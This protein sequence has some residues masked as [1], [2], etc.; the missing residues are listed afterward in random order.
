MDLAEYFGNTTG[1]GVLSTADSEGN[2]NSALYARPHIMED[3]T[4]VLLMR[5]R[6][7]LANLQS[8]PKA[9][10]LFL[11]SGTGYKGKR[12]FLEKIKEERDPDLISSL[13]RRP[14]HENS[15]D[16]ETTHAVF[17]EITREMPLVGRRNK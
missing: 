4:F 17:F 9:A 14:Y 11:E 8:N 1:T 2:V 5:E 13:R 15:G 16:A 3:G 6:L 10:Y 7:S 12:F